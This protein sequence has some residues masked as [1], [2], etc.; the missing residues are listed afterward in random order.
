MEFDMSG[1][2]LAAQGEDYREYRVR[3]VI[4]GSPAAEA[5]VRAGDLLTAVDGKPTRGL[6]LG[7]LRQL[8]RL[9]EQTYNIELL[10]DGAIRHVAI[11]TRRLV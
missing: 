1:M 8:L 3:M 2:S 10:R 4:G 7:E 6:S 5:G 9:E 11:R